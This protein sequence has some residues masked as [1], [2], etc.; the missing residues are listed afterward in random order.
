MVEGQ[1]V[2]IDKLGIQTSDLS[3]SELMQVVY[4]V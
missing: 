1:N 2:V 4:S 3:A